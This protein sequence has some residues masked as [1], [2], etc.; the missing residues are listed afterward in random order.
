MPSLLNLHILEEELII[1]SLSFL[2]L[3]NRA[4][5]NTII[6]FQYFNPFNYHLHINVY[7]YQSILFQPPDF[8]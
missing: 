7:E 8:L 2:S 6:Y 3:D 5:F 1:V 4:I